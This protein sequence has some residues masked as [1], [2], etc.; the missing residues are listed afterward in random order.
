MIGSNGKDGTNGTNGKDGVGVSTTTINSYGE[1]VITYSDGTST[2]LGVV[3]G[4]DGK[5][6]TNGLD[7]KDGVDGK[8]GING[9]DGKNGV[10]GKDGI[11]GLDG[12]DGIDGIGVAKSEI[13]S[14]GELVITYSN[15]ISTNLGTVVG[16]DGK[17][18]VDGKD[19]INGAD[20]KDGVD[21]K[22]GIDGTNGQDGI[23]IS[24]VEINTDNELVLSFSDSSSI[25]LGCI[26]GKDG[27]DGKDGIDGTNGKDGTNGVDGV[28]IAN[29]TI[30]DEGALS[31]ELTNGTILNLGNIKGE[32]GIGISKSEINADGEFVL[33]YTNGQSTN[34]G[35]VVG[36]DGINGT[37]GADGKD[38]INGADGKDGTGIVNVT[39]SAEGALS[40]ELSNGTVLNLGN[41]KGADGIGIS[42]SEINSNGELL[43]TYTSGETANLG[44]VVGAK[45]AD[46]KDGIG[47]KTV[48]LSA[49]GELS[50]LLTDNT[51]LNLGN[52]KGEKGD[53]GEKG[54]KG[55]K[56]ADGK[57]GV[58][59]K[60]GRGIADMA[61]INGE[62]VITYT[63]GTKSVIGKSDDVILN[64]SDTLEFTLL[65]DGTYAVTGCLVDNPTEI[66]IPSKFNGK[67]VTKIYS[68]AFENIITL[69]TVNIPNS[70]LSI[71][72]RAFYGCNTLKNVNISTDSELQEIAGYAFYGCSALTD[73]YFPTYVDYIGAYAFYQSGLTTAVFECPTNWNLFG[74]WN[75]GYP[76]HLSPTDSANAAKALSTNYTSHTSSDFYKNA[77][78]RNDSYSNGSIVGTYEREL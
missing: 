41:I 43:L 53:T 69:K 32:N 15:G 21:G 57:D 1:L 45:G 31:V 5:D 60:D 74:K 56:G 47:I 40:V 44:V 17:D 6:G 71:G 70:I 26:V 73:I 18:G 30:S 78:I 13:N 58:D 16:K 7:G 35:K 2:N 55:D 48:T 77:W 25:N 75:N 11:N 4:A 8:D 38:G 24:N 9:T 20:G 61:I 65:S 27:A 36:A 42:K 68:N 49:D 10:D 22:D 76:A 12:K 34:L 52:V 67:F 39:I 29:V 62:I 63:D 23:G 66:T 54:E 50:I 51:V 59:G 19:G 72:T 33:T 46:G 64:E 3:V 14:N 37:N 28:G